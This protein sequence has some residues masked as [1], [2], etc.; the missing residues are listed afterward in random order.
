M[1]RRLNPTRDLAGAS[2]FLGEAAGHMAAGRFDAAAVAYERAARADPAD[3]RAPF[4]LATL[5]LRR[6]RPDLALPRLKRVVTLRPDLFDAQ[7]NLGAAAQGVEAWEDAAA[8]YRAA[9]ALRP[10]A[11]ETRR[12]LGIVLVILGRVDEA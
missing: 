6:G 5:D 1:A 12:N 7:H 8:A 4:S 9:L 10:D 3:F 2:R 11:I